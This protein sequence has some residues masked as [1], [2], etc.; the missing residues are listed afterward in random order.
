M[1]LP[2]DDRCSYAPKHQGSNIFPNFFYFSKL[3]R[4][5]HKP[6]LLAVKDITFGYTATYRQL[7]T[8]VLHFRNIL[9]QTLDAS[10]I[11]K[12][13]RDEEV[14]MNLLGP[15][16]YEFT[17]AFLALMALGAV[18]VPISLDLSTLR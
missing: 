8:D 2:S 16:G 10:V 11:A 3:V 17:V 9:R 15:G 6:N 1:S 13:D 14:F 18:V 4:L 12:I 7:L 5:A